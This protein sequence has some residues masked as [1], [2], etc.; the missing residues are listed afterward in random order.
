VSAVCW[1]ATII[2]AFQS[3]RMIGTKAENVHAYRASVG[4]QWAEFVEALYANGKEAW[5]YQV[6]DDPA[7]RTLP[8]D[9]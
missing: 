8:R 6:P 2:V 1:A 7:S 5:G 4:D 9:L 3:S